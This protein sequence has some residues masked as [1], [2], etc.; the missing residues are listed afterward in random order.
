MVIKRHLLRDQIRE[1]LLH[2]IGSGELAPGHRIV[3]ARICEE[4]GVSAIPV[5][6]AIR[7]LVAM[8]LLEFAN[9]KGAWVREVSLAETIEALQVR[10]ALE[11]V[12]AIPAAVKLR[13]Q[14]AELRRCYEGLLTAAR[15]RDYIAFQDHNQHFHRAIVEASG[16]GVLLRV[17]NSLGFEVRTRAIMEFLAKRDALAIAREHETI[18]AALDAG[19]GKKAS[20][21]MASHSNH[22]VEYLRQQQTTPIHE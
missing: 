11:S 16:N 9:H 1:A 7:E 2:R 18:I 12:A 3:E 10:A 14:S 5:R 17:W 6:E 4:M 21:L 22:L 13:G 20:A 15:R 8:G 19:D